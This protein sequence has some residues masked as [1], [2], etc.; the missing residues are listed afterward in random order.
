MDTDDHAFLRR[1]IAAAFA[2]RVPSLMG[3][4]VPLAALTDGDLLL[5]LLLHA[6]SFVVPGCLKLELVASPEDD[7]TI[8][9]CRV[10]GFHLFCRSSL[11]EAI[12]GVAGRDR[13]TG[14][15]AT[16][17][18]HLDR[19][20]WHVSASAIPGLDETFV[21]AAVAR[22]LRLAASACGTAKRVDDFDDLGT[23]GDDSD[24]DF[25]Y[26]PETA[27]GAAAAGHEAVPASRTGTAVLEA[28]AAQLA[29]HAAEIATTLVRVASSLP[30]RLRSPE[31]DRLSSDVGSRSDVLRL[32][33]DADLMDAAVS[34]ICR[35]GSLPASEFN[36]L[37]LRHLR[38]DSIEVACEWV[39]GFR[40]LEESFKGAVRAAIRDEH[41]DFGLA[42][43]RGRMLLELVA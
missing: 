34:E 38:R 5:P 2:G 26:P 43:V 15:T 31:G 7:P 3:M 14:A 28:M 29:F 39:Q 18:V 25:E 37:Q 9:G 36:H 22:F 16:L 42:V 30:S 1:E 6:C 23:D 13:A 32:A 11:S 21:R 40:E 12:H 24:D 33:R 20:V 4:A 10:S 8:L 41:V 35:I 17:D 27:I 19:F